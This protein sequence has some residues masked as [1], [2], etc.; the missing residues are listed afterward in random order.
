MPLRAFI[1]GKELISI[2]LLDQEWAILKKEVRGK[3]LSVKLPCCGQN[4][5]LRVSSKGLKHFV[6]SKDGTPCDWESE[7]PQH[8]KSKVEIAKA[9][10]DSGWLAI[11][12]Y[13]END[14]RA[15]ILATK[16]EARIA[17]E[18]QWSTQTEEDTNF[19]QK[20][21]RDANVR[22]CWFFKTPPKQL[23]D[24]ITANPLTIEELPLF[25][26]KEN[27][28]KEIVVLNDAVTKG[29]YQHVCDLLRGHIKYAPAY[30][31]LPEQIL[32]I[33]FFKT[34]CWKCGAEQHMYFADIIAQSYCG[35]KLGADDTGLTLHP[36]VIK[37][38]QEIVGSPEGKNLKLGQ[39]KERYS[40]TA[41]R[42]YI[43]FGCYFCDA[44]FGNFYTGH[45]ECLEARYLD[46][47]IKFKRPISLE[48]SEET[49][50]W[51]YSE[52]GAFCGARGR[53]AS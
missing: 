18:V 51:C 8:L 28:Q 52:T 25:K 23:R 39:I 4:G 27:E 33:S 2:N 26:I 21:Y 30:S 48:I 44:L 42:A 41:G 37:V 43:S 10:K 17:F 1:N 12:E 35:K 3:S 13:S 47:N 6:H 38:A 45:H 49:P 22:G 11:P 29:L 50:H 15:D 19:R 36:K 20:R 31:A 9:C 14:W 40:R 46:G 16:G 34:N 53:F 5:F 24:Q 32:E 7:T